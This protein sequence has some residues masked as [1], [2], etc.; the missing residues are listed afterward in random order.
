LNKSFHISYS[1]HSVS[2]GYNAVATSQ[3]V[4]YVTQ[5]SISSHNAY[6]KNSRMKF[7]QA[8]FFPIVKD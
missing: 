5:Q 2:L 4:L 7:G 6:R 1:A 3:Y 8:A